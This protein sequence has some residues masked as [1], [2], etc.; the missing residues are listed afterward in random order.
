[1]WSRFVQGV[2]EWYKTI[3]GGFWV[4]AGSAIFKVVIIILLVY[5]LRKFGNYLIDKSIKRQK[6]LKITID[7]RK[8]DTLSSILKSILMYLLYFIGILSIL[9]TL[10]I[11]DT[12]AVLATAGIG[13]LAV[14]FGAQNL[15]KDVI[16]GFFILLEDQFSVGDFVTIGDATGTVEN[17]GLRITRIRNYK[18]DLYIIPNGEIKQVINSTRGDYMAVVDV[19]ISYE[20][21]I[22]DAIAVLNDLFER[23]F[24]ERDEIIE[25]PMVL[26]VQDLGDYNVIIR[27]AAKV[28][29]MQQ[30][31]VERYMKQKIKEEFDK[32][33][34]KIPYPRRVIYNINEE[35]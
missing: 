29:S 7:D 30:W 22:Q 3:E 1:M 28:K 13:G 6:K 32:R 8:L 17:I 2:T 35:E 5:I 20:E 33:G 11:V 12:K 10:N 15:V 4:K 24:Q 18:G 25:K 9:D 26:G 19:S 21:N 14:G 34:I 27:S 16:N 23:I 31:A